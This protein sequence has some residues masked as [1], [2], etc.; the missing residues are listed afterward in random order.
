VVKIPKNPNKRVE[1]ELSIEED[2]RFAQWI[3][4][5][6]SQK[7]VEKLP[8][9]ELIYDSTLK[10]G[11]QYTY[12]TIQLRSLIGGARTTV[13]EYGHHIEHSILAIHIAADTFLKHRTHTESSV[14]GYE[15]GTRSYEVK[16]DN[17]FDSYCGRMYPFEYDGEMYSSTEIVSMGLA[18]MYD[19]PGEFMREDPEYFQFM[20]AVM[21]GDYL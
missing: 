12:N 19:A 2:Q 18:R 11:G 10:N 7:V 1:V 21:K 8:D 9:V 3:K 13:H 14:G 4:N 5:N 15:D 20:L 6:V 16:K 17:F